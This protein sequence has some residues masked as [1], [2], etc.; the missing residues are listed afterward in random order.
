MDR[1]QQATQAIA[2]LMA[3]HPGCVISGDHPRWLFGTHHVT[4]G[5]F[6]GRP[7]VF[8]YYGWLPRKVQEEKALRLYAP[9][10]LV[11]EVFPVQSESVLVIERLPGCTLE[12]VQFPD[13]SDQSVEVYR[14][15]GRSLAHIVTLAPGGDMA[16]LRDLSVTDGVDYEFFCQA[17]TTLL[18][19]TVVERCGGVLAREE[20]PH[21]PIL[22]ESLAKLRRNRDAIVSFPSFMQV[23]DFHPNNIMVDGTA[24][25]GLIDLEMTRYGNE[26]LVLAAAFAALAVRGTPSR[27]QSF[28]Q[29]YQ[30]R[31][32]QSI[33]PDMAELIVAA[34][35]FTQWIRFMWYW[36]ADVHAIEE[37]ARGWPIRDIKAVDGRRHIV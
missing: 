16:G 26:V 35:S 9:T 22:R 12:H 34:A 14:N 25:A 24:V 36:T 6:N 2:R 21:A 17:D 20:V 33:S 5:S 19:D 13:E 32:G 23:D 3:E 18:F 30:E 1:E 8:K 10:G 31:R 29:G 28:L 37:G 11:P 15:L 4:F 7:A 27:W